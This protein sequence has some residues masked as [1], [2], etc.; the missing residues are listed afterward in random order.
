[1]HQKGPDQKIEAVFDAR[2]APSANH[3]SLEKIVQKA[4]S[5]ICLVIHKSENR[6]SKSRSDLK[7]SWVTTKYTL[8]KSTQSEEDSQ[9]YLPVC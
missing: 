5:L 9:K 6:N 2:L 8:S 3:A 7:E 1:M 4:K